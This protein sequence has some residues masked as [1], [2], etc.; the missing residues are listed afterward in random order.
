MII[1]KLDILKESGVIDAEI[2]DFVRA[3]MVC[4]QDEGID[5]SSEAA[6]PFLIHLAVAAAR[7]KTDDAPIER[8]DEMICDDIEQDLRFPGVKAIWEKLMAFSPVSFR[9]EELH[10]C[11]AHI[12]TML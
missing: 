7:Q 1:K 11:Y 6:E 12:C 5:V 10:Y 9:E 3:A 8:M 4:L 2:Y